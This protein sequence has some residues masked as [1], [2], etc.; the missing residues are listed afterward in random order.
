MKSHG[1]G[2][3][4]PWQLE[5]WRAGWL[6]DADQRRDHELHADG[7]TAF[8]RVL[9][10]PEGWWALH[11]VTRPRRQRQSPV[12]MGHAT[13]RQQQNPPVPSADEAGLSS[14]NI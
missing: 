10:G 2:F 4:I 13:A 12:G 6:S 14:Y 1:G 7:G 3:E 11:M 9:L 8:S 5:I